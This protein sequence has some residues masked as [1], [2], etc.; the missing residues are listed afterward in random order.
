[1][2]YKSQRVVLPDGVVSAAVVT[3][4]GQIIAVKG[5]DDSRIAL[6]INDEYA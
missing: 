6:G 2:V 3:K 5:Y 1:M 4:N